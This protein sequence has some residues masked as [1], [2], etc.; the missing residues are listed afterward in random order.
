[1]RHRAKCVAWKCAIKSVGAATCDPRPQ[2]TEERTSTT[3][4]TLQEDVL[5]SRGDK[6]KASSL[7]HL[8]LVQRMDREVPID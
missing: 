4:E 2:R 3:L 7:I 5:K 1:M 6:I 8:K